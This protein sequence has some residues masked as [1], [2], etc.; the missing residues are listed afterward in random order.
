MQIVSRRPRARPASMEND[1]KNPLIGEL[2]H[3]AG[4]LPNGI[5]TFFGTFALLNGGNHR[6]RCLPEEYSNHTVPIHRRAW[7]LLYSF[8][9]NLPDFF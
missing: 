8:V 5:P 2:Y 4:L 6:G 9:G 3:S 7:D 1:C